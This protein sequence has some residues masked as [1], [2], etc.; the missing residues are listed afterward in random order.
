MRWM[1]EDPWAFFCMVCV[2]VIALLFISL[3][4]M[5]DTPQPE[6]RTVLVQP[7]VD[8]VAGEGKE[9]IVCEDAE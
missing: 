1:P 3:A 5:E 9:F 7:V 2:L 8:G 6:C 4:V